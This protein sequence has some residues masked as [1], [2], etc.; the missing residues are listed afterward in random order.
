LNNIILKVDGYQEGYPE[1]IQEETE[2]K[3]PKEVQE[4]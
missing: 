1:E 3:T 4:E 2:G